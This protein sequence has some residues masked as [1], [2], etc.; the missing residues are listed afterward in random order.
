M[1]I[2]RLGSGFS[3]IKKGEMPAPMEGGAY[4]ALRQ[5]RANARYQ[6]AKEKRARD[7][8]AD[9]TAKK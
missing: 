4:V 1:P 3:E 5:A 7:K 8:T 2:D 9:E 6:G